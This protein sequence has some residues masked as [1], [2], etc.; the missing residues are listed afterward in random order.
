MKISIIT[1]SYHNALTIKDTIKSVLDQTYHGLEYIIVDGASKD[2]T[3][4]IIRNY[5]ELFQGRMKWVS[6]PDNGIYDA[7]NKGLLMA[8]GDVIGF[9]N[10]DDYY[11]DNQVLE[12]I[13]RAFTQYNVDAIHGN[14]N[15]INSDRK[16]VRIWQGKQYSPGSFQRGWNPAH[17]TF[18]CK[19]ECFDKYGSFDPTIGSAADFELMLRFI[20]KHQIITQYINRSMIYMRTGGSSTSGITAVLRNTKQNKQAFVKNHIYFPW[21][22]SLSRLCI[23]IFSI[24]SLLKYMCGT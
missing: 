15:Y 7:M 22:Y 11:Q 8:T 5:E 12:D 21:H 17:P 10:A 2:G 9:L 13:A 3:Q 6:E 16:I 23:K 4:D 1:V 24:R 19:K 20:E 14:L 18:Y